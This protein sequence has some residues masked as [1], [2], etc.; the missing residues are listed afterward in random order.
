MEEESGK[1]AREILIK[2]NG[3]LRKV[4]FLARV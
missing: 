1:E 2:K 3:E 4:R